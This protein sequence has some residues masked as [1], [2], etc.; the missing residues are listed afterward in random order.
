MIYELLLENAN[1]TMKIKTFLLSIEV[2]VIL[3]R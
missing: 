3:P 2:L 1:L